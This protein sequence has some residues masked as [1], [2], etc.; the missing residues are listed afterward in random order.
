MLLLLPLELEVDQAAYGGKRHGGRLLC[1]LRYSASV[2]GYTLARVRSPA[3]LAD[4]LSLYITST[5]TEP[6]LLDDV[7]SPCIYAR[8][9]SNSS[10]PLMQ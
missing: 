2:R 8:F 4:N 7:I 5:N 10:P 9:R 1:G 3:D 6:R